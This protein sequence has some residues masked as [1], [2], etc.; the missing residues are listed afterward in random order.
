[1]DEKEIMIQQ[2]API[3]T[4][5][6]V[7][8][9]KEIQPLSLSQYL[10]S[11]V[12][13]FFYPADHTF[14]C[15]TEICSFSDRQPEFTAIN[16]Q[17]IAVSCDSTFS[18]LA[19]INMPRSQGGLGDMKIPIVSDMDKSIAKKYGVLIE[20]EGVPL[21]GLFIIS[22]T[23][24]L[25]Q[26]T[27]NDLP[28][29]RNVDE[30]VRLV[31][32]F[33]FTD[34]HGEVCPANWQP[35]SATMNPDPI[36]SKEY[37][38]SSSDGRP[39][40][41]NTAAGPGEVT[42]IRFGALIQP[43]QNDMGGGSTGMLGW[44]RR[45]FRSTLHDYCLSLKNHPLHTRALTASVLAMLGELLGVFVR[46]RRMI[47]STTK[48]VRG[49]RQS[50]Y[51]QFLG[52]DGHD[53][54][55]VISLQ[56]LLSFG[57][58]GLVIGGPVSHYWH[59][60]MNHLLMPVDASTRGLAG[61]T[62]LL[63]RVGLS[64]VGRSILTLSYHSNYSYIILSQLIIHTISIQSTLSC[65]LMSFADFSAPF[66]LIASHHHDS[67]IAFVGRDGA[68]IFCCH[69]GGSTSS[70]GTDPF[71]WQCPSSRYPITHPLIYIPHIHRIH[72]VTSS[73]TPSDI[74]L[75]PPLIHPLLPL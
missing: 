44:M 39:R 2:P 55:N 69:G 53:G 68:A 13:L 66:S 58:C 51:K 26:T 46:H 38:A 36:K 28:V 50:H 61:E 59:V 60:F 23:G 21:R 74:S 57:L 7:Y 56:R 1:M 12:V 71:R 20:D 32:A 4:A 49:D 9:N 27:V 25:R 6:A 33:Q 3:F 62:R 37:F 24:I 29:G 19:W 30:I 16:T 47:M 48:N 43:D 63:L 42:N 67:F 73:T 34:T 15:P 72:L 40:V 18:H 75:T 64:Q 22:P 35:G 8:P 31:Q 70:H 5:Q 14:V 10:G 65:V 54:A 17:V 11:Y 52:W 45:Q 41:T